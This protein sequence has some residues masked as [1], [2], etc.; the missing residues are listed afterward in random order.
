MD[1]GEGVN[2]RAGSGWNTVEDCDRLRDTIRSSPRTICANMQGDFGLECRLCDELSLSLEP[3]SV[4]WWKDHCSRLLSAP[5]TLN[6]ARCSLMT[7]S[8]L[9]LEGWSFS[10]MRRRGQSILWNIEGTNATCLLGKSTRAPALCQK[11]NF[12]PPSNR[13]VSLHPMTQWCLCWFPSGYR[14]T[15]RNY[16]A[17]LAGKLAQWISNTVDMSSVTAEL[18]QDGVMVLHHAHPIKCNI[19]WKSKISPLWSKNIWPPFSPD[20]N[21]LENAFWPHIEAR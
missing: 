3:S 12:Q 9:F 18:Q 19:S 5:S 14:L 10:Q 4:S 2:R 15:A 17:K 8:L 16:E 11:R 6:I 20:A 13:L 21:P 7:S 1:D